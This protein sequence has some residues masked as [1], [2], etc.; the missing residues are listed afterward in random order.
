MPG[1]MLNLE[2]TTVDKTWSL[3]SRHS[4]GRREGRQRCGY[5][6]LQALCLEHEG[7]TEYWK[8]TTKI[9]SVWE[10][11]GIATQSGG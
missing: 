10:S 5:N 1:S 7:H 8:L 2:D 4:Q 6:D 11:R 9:G 3:T